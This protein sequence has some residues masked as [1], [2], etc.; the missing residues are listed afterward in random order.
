MVQEET[1]EPVNELCDLKVEPLS[2]VD[3]NNAAARLQSRDSSDDNIFEILPRFSIT[4]GE[5]NEKWDAKYERRRDEVPT[6][7]ALPQIL[8]ILT[9]KKRILIG[10]F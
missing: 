3:I 10:I 9:N 1:E 5:T 8:Y 4:G 6:K 2:G 7:T